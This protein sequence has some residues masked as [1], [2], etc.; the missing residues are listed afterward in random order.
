MGIRLLIPQGSL[1]LD[2]EDIDRH[3]DAYDSDLLSYTW[4][5]DDSE[6]D[7]LA[8]VLMST[9]EDA[10]VSGAGVSETFM[11]QWLAVVEGTDL[12]VPDD[13]I[14]QGAI[15]GRPRLTESWFC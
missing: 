6:M 11:A 7:R 9:A 4:S 13:P 8:A 12:E 14:D 5:A 3:L 15:V 10:A 2:V 1:I